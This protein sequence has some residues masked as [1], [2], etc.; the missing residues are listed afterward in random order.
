MQDTN[1]RSPCQLCMRLFFPQNDKM[2][3]VFLRVFFFLMFFALRLDGILCL[4]MAFQWMYS[5]RVCNRNSVS[6]KNVSVHVVFSYTMRC[7]VELCP[8][9]PQTEIWTWT[10]ESLML[11]CSKQS[12]AFMRI[13][14]V[15]F[16][17]CCNKSAKQMFV[18]W[19][20]FVVFFFL[21]KTLAAF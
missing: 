16:C 2:N 21:L 7:T 3:Q 18:S 12:E 6:K 20:F 11:C 13:S 14:P 15:G 8:R 17:V 5:S 10:F 9:S 19:I 4:R 1:M